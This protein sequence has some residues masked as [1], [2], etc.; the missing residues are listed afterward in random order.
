MGLTMPR[1]SKYIFPYTN[2]V[3]VLFDDGNVVENLNVNGSALIIPT[4]DLL[5]EYFPKADFQTKTIARIDKDETGCGIWLN[6]CDSIL[7]AQTPTLIRVVGADF[8]KPS[9]IID[10]CKMLLMSEC[11]FVI[12]TRANSLKTDIDSPLPIVSHNIMRGSWSDVAGKLTIVF[13]RMKLNSAV[14]FQLL[15]H[16]LSITTAARKW[17]GRGYLGDV[18]GIFTEGFKDSC[19]LKTAYLLS[20]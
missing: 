10:Y 14:N 13:E 8:D 6:L 3:G 20:G 7:T 12:D 17:F 11:G 15:V 2:T 19:Q 16:G 18:S 1:R 4:L 9:P 5:K